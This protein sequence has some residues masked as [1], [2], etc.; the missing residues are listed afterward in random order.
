MSA[1]AYALLVAIILGLIGFGGFVPGV[2]HSPPLDAPSLLLSDGY[3][4][5]LGLF[6]VNVLDC[7]FYL[8]LATYG[9]FAWNRLASPVTFA[10]MVTVWF[11][12]ATV[13]GLIEP[14]STG[15]GVLPVFGLDV[16]LHATLS[17][18]GAVFGFIRQPTSAALV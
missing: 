6:P 11:A 16:L 5:V 3:G 8:A 1:R 7:L 10:R 15:F 9:F 13:M 14:A 2:S 12:V 18:S 17:A 4:F